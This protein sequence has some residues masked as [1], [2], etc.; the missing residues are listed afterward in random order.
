M[1]FWKHPGACLLIIS[2]VVLLSACRNY[3]RNTIYTA[4]TRDQIERGEA[5]AHIYCQSCHLF[6]E[7]S[8]LD[9]GSWDKGVLPGMGPRLGI[10]SF[11]FKHYPS[12]LRDQTLEKGYYPSKPLLTNQQWSDILAFYLATSP[13]SLPGQDRER[14]IRN[15]LT[16][17][18]PVSPAARYYMPTTCYIK[19]DSS[20]QT[21][22]TL[23][24]G[25]AFRNKLYRFDQGLN[26]VDSAS[27]KG[28]VVD[29][30]YEKNELLACNIG[31]L[32]P[33][34]GKHG[35]AQPIRVSADGKMTPDSLPLF[36]SLQR[37]VQITP[38]DI[39]GD[40]KMD[41]VVC[42]FGFLTGSLSWME[43]LGGNRF[44]RHVIRAVPG[45]IK[46]YV[47]D[48][49][50]DGLPDLWVLFAQGDEGIFL[51]TNKGK[52]EFT[53][54]P[55]LRFPPIYGSCYFEL[56][57]F[58]GDGY[59]DILYTCG[60]NGDFSPVLKPYHG[61]Y[62]FLN[63]GKNHFTQK[64]FYPINGCYKAIAR[65]FDGDGDLDIATIS[66]FA[67]Y[68][69]QPEE[70]FVYLENKGNFKFEPHTLAAGRSGRWLTMDAGDFDGDGKTDLLLGN[71]SVAPGPLKSGTDWKK[72]PP[73]LFLKNI[74]TGK[75]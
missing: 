57:D 27:L 53:T 55:V 68:A 49:N 35:S 51:F 43:N 66:F 28:P 10:F 41:Y 6:P 73:F 60:D 17:F 25:D 42:E 75:N 71:F 5:L 52:G 18:S 62:I 3:H 65:D 4:V 67:D 30:H 36:D 69:H 61:V 34:N 59:P 74:G 21:G 48:Y 33:N 72:N 2:G 50:H 38:V 8:L 9:A 70:G 22:K 12:Y 19:V 39:N 31:I 24:V 11:E 32:L 16:L 40:G 46:V 47:T 23:L 14:P 13:D 29:I 63:D 1:N 56:D 15:D 54:D 64:Y 45:A 44:K 20:L 37:P 7:P 26:L 58:N